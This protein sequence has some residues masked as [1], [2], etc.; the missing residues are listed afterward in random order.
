MKNIFIELTAK[1]D[2]K[3]LLNVMTIA[4]VEPDKSGSVIKSNMIHYS[5][6]TKVKESYEDVKSKIASLS[7]QQ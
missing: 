2:S 1:D 6:S 3:I 4:W 7:S 5:I